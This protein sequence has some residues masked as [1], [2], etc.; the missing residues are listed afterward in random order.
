MSDRLGRFPVL[1]FGYGAV[2]LG[3]A[4]LMFVT[5]FWGFAIS[6]IFASLFIYATAGV[7]TA[8]V[9]D[10]STAQQLP[11]SVGL[12]EACAWSGGLVGY[13]ATGYGLQVF[14]AGYLAAVGA[15]A[16]LASVFVALTLARDRD[17]Q[18]GNPVV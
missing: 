15:L 14:G 3:V 1:A 12:Y 6:S 8:V 5:N 18:W 7:R 9:G 11:R 17:R 16:G 2:A 10:I 4:S 13:A